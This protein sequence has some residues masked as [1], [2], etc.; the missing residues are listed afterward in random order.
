M[1]LFPTKKKIVATNVST[2]DDEQMNLL[3][4]ES[5]TVREDVELLKIVNH[6]M[7]SSLSDLT[8]RNNNLERKFDE[9]L[10]VDTFSLFHFTIYIDI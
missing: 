4:H 10:K 9:L 8:N 6:T 7:K 3:R 1:E 2:V 5:R